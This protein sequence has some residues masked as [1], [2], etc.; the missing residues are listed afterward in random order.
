MTLNETI[1]KRKSTPLSIRVAR[2]LLPVALFYVS[3]SR[4]N[5]PLTRLGKELL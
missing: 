1:Y 5:Q 3:I 2:A 4:V